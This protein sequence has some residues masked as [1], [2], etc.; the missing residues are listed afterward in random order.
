L[1]ILD[2]ESASLGAGQKFPGDVAFKLYDTYGFPLDLTQDALKS[3]AIDVDVDGFN[4]CME[5]QKEQARK[6]WTGS[7]ATATDKIWFDLLEQCGATE[8]LGYD[9]EDAEGKI[10]ALLKDGKPVDSA[11]PGDI[12]MVVVNQTPFYAESGGQVGDT[13]RILLTAGA[14]N[15]NVTDTR[16]QLGKLWVHIGTVESG[17]YTVGAPV[18]LIVD[19][20]RRT[21][22]R[23]N[24]SV[25]HLL[26]AALRQVLGN[27]VSQKGSLQ[28]DERTRFDISHGQA[29]TRDQINAVEKIVTEQ[30]AANTDITTRLLPLDEAIASG[31]MALFGEKYDDEVRVVSMGTLNPATGNPY[32]VELCGGTHARRTGEIGAFK[33]I[34]ESAV[35]AGIR[36]V[37]ALTGARVGTYLARQ[38][39]AWAEKI[40]KLK[41]E[42][43]A[44]RDELTSLGGSDS[45]ALAN[46]EDDLLA[47]KKALQKAIADLRRKTAADAMEDN[48][49]KDIAGVK[50]TARVLE[51][52]PARDLKPMV[53][54]L[55]KKLGSGVITL[56]ATDDGKA[57][58]VVGVT[59]DLTAK[60]SAVELVKC[61]VAALGGQGGGGRADMAQGG[62]PNG[63]A[64][65]DAVSAIEKA[66]GA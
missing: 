37:E 11:V 59:D 42:I 29:I 35:S 66:L 58:I 31:A 43:A 39:Q 26:H 19:S 45:A 63:A 1:K 2:E 41:G 6:S 30:I 34:S 44:L 3:R 20:E 33:I 60:L 18:R 57:S 47:H 49:V 46:S 14:G 28:D 9:R 12:V 8:F 27:H 36:R 17:T 48:T 24:H 65:N 50:F 40:D 55:K 54:D 5:K 7:G 25:T 32:S 15:L 38:E 23:A 52:F 53:D 22:I 10:L 62:G 16:K 56:I 61:G 64:A 4:A 51:G 21:A 13:G